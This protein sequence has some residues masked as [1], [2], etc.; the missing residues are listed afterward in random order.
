MKESENEDNA[1]SRSSLASSGL[2]SVGEATGQA[3]SEGAA[4]AD[5]A[6]SDSEIDRQRNALQPVSLTVFV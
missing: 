4:I 2:S 5:G 3:S 6:F 1:S